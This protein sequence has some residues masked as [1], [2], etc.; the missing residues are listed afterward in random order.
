MTQK[1]SLQR[2]TRTMHNELDA[3]K[4][5]VEVNGFMQDNQVISKGEVMKAS[6][7]VEDSEALELFEKLLNTE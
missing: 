1:H 3:E 6:L 4:T 2:H 7:S 5:L